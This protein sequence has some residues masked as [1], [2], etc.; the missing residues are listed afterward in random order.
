MAISQATATSRAAR[1]LGFELTRN[2][3]HPY[4][5]ANIADFWKRWHISLSTWLRDYIF[6][7]FS[8]SM[9]LRYG[10][11]HAT[12]IQIAAHLVT[13]LASGLW[14]GA[15]LTFVLWGLLHGVYL[16]A[17]CLLPTRKLAPASPAGKRLWRV[18]SVLAT[19]HL[20]LL[21]W[22]LFR[23]P[24]VRVVP[25]VYR[26][27]ADGVIVGLGSDALNLFLP[28]IALYGVMLAIDA[29]QRLTAEDVFFRRLPAGARSLIYMSA[30]SLMIFFAVKPY[31]P[32]IYFRF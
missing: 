3:N 25:D 8:R 24:S 20:V 28:V 5:A 29:G 22:V 4:F 26:R 17:Y 1:L 30:I 2:F 19:F 18:F 12:R 15:N 32:F 23:T 14:H 21:A 10:S 11:R 13:M 6:Y 9:L 7:P 31:V 27:L 16:S